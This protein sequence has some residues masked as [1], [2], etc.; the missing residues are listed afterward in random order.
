MKTIRK[1]L[2][3]FCFFETLLRGGLI[4]ISQL[5]TLVE[6]VEK[7]TK[8]MS[9]LTPGMADHTVELLER[10]TTALLPQTK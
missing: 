9:A 1:N 10:L 5:E 7:R 6:E 8:N 2:K 3:L 4:S